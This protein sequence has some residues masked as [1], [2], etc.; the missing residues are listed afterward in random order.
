MNRLKSI[1]ACAVPVEIFVK[2][3]VCI[4]VAGVPMSR[5]TARFRVHMPEW[6]LLVQSSRRAK[7][8]SGPFIFMESADDDEE[9]NC[10]IC[11]VT[12]SFFPDLRPPHWVPALENVHKCVMCLCILH[13]ECAIH[14]SQGMPPLWDGDRFACP[15]CLCRDE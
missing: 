15:L 5:S 1:V 3:E 11:F 14:V 2:A 13:Q 6:C 7:L 9:S 8:F 10:A 12:G 4:V